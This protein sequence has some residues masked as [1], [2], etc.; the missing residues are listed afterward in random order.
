MKDVPNA[1]KYKAY[2]RRAMARFKRG[3]YQAGWLDA[4]EAKAIDDT[5]EIVALTHDIQGKWKSVDERGFLDC[6]REYKVQGYDDQDSFVPIVSCKAKPPTK[7][8]I[9][10]VEEVEPPVVVEKDN[11]KPVSRKM[12]IQEVQEE[13]PQK[14]TAS[15]KMMIEEVDEE[16]SVVLPSFV[17]SQEPETTPLVIPSKTGSGKGKMLIEEIP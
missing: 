16:P 12:V 10:E 1:I 7:M 2:H 13:E 11:V 14:K 3:K 17:A 6:M 8:T 4:R 15:R 9:E 5:K